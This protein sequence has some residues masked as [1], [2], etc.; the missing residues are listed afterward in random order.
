MFSYKLRTDVQQEKKNQGCCLF[1]I[2]TERYVYWKTKAPEALINELKTRWLNEDEMASLFGP[3]ADAPDWATFFYYFDKLVSAGFLSARFSQNDQP[4]FSVSPALPKSA[5]QTLQLNPETRCRLSRFSLIRQDE[6]KMVLESALT[7]CRFILHKKELAEL[8]FGLCGGMVLD[9]EETEFSVLL[10]AL[11]ETGIIEIARTAQPDPQASL[12]AWEFHDLF[13]YSRTQKGRHSFP[14]GGTYRFTGERKSPPVVK[15]IVSNDMIP[16]TRPDG[17]LLEKIARPFEMILEARRSKRNYSKAPV[18]LAELA[19]F[20]FYSSRIQGFVQDNVHDE[21]LSLRP[22][23]SGGA[24]HAFE[25]YPVVRD[26][27][28]CEPG[29]YRYCPQKQGLEK[30]KSPDKTIQKLLD[31]NPHKIIS[32]ISPHIT[33]YIS[34]RFE[35]MSWKYES[36]AYKLIQQ[37]LGCLYQ[38]FYLVAEALDLGPCALGDVDAAL[39]GKVLEIDWQTEPFIGGF[40]LGK[41]DE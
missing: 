20:L 17:I 9:T 3:S 10:A 14:I 21:V 26:C 6:G 32:P 22:S 35:R 12:D 19:A 41:C 39:L 31:W 29:V 25:I 27:E 5:Y 36:I 18:S 11:N 15:P 40:T 30:I 34:A 23:P 1:S 37:D 13:F 7:P 38:T 33:L 28:N 24:R 16:L 4:V 2:L 8:L